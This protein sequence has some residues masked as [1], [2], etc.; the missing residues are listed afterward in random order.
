VTLLEAV[1]AVVILGLSA[2]GYLDLYR[3]SAGAARDAREWTQVVAAA[4]AAMEGATL[5]D[6]VQARA[7]LP[8]AEPAPETPARGAPSLRARVEV[9]PWRDGVREIVVTVT[10]AGGVSFALHRLSRER[11]P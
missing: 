3:S 10:S 2:V 5:G 6:A 9:R 4:E 1:I 8:D 11:Q 7:G